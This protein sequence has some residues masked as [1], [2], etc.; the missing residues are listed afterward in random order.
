MAL[1]NKIF[2]LGFIFVSILFHISDSRAVNIPQRPSNYIV[3][4]ANIVDSATESQ[5]NAY[6]RELEQKTTVQLVVLTIES[7]EG[8]AIEDFS[9]RIAHDRWKLG[10]RGKDNGLLLVI[11]VKERKYRIEVGYGL[12]GVL[13]DSL[14]GSI[15][16]NYLVPFFQKGDYADGI[17]A[18]V[19]ELANV[20]A[21]DAGV[22][23]TGVPGLKRSV[24]KE[25][26][27]GI[28]GR[29]ITA[30]VFVFLLLLFLRHPRAFLLFFLFSSMGG[31]RQT[32]GGG[33]G[34]GFGGGGFGSFGGGG[35][36]GFGGGG[37]SGG[38]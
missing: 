26:P 19:L 30:V 37:A 4:L 21:K 8:E 24:K 12:E 5:L 6:L 9:I 16:R 32:W 34:S 14:V 38:W 33:L 10:R 35:G 20:V 36:G 27:A 7:L 17:R 31:G 3:D 15:G 23:I 18:T 29:I 22:K 28:L 13:P 25:Q 2:L 1:R 11:A